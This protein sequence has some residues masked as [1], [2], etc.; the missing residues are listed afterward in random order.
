LAYQSALEQPVV[1]QQLKEPQQPLEEVMV[2]S[3]L[4]KT[5]VKGNYMRYAF[6]VYI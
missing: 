2:V 1:Y 4:E 5:F 6:W 3:F